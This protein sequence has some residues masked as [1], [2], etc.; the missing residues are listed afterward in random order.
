HKVAGFVTRGVSQ[1]QELLVFRHPLG[2][3]QLPTGTVEV[4][5]EIQAAVL[6]EVAEETGLNDMR[7][8]RHLASLPESWRPDG[9]MIARTTPFYAEPR[10][11]A[12]TLPIPLAP[13]I[14]VPHAGRGLSCRLLREEGRDVVEAGYV[15]VGFDMFHLGGG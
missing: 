9:R 12:A 15:R 7:L 3:L 13:G 6:R 5:E 2:G 1:A 4:G 14:S 10:E 8:V 11:T